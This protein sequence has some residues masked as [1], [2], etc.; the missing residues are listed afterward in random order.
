MK[1]SPVKEPTS[2]TI[3]VQI[4]AH[5]W[6]DVA[7]FFPL[8]GHHKTKASNAECRRIVVLLIWSGLKDSNCCFSFSQR[9]MDCMSLVGSKKRKRVVEYFSQSQ[10]FEVAQNYS[11]GRNSIIWKLS[12]AKVTRVSGSQHSE[13]DVD[14][15]AYLR[16]RWQYAG[17]V[18]TTD[19]SLEW[20]QAYDKS[21]NR[22]CSLLWPEQ[23]RW[24][25]CIESS[26]TQLVIGSP[27]YEDC[28][29]AATHSRNL[30]GTSPEA[31]AAMYQ[32]SWGSFQ[33]RPLLYLIRK[34]G[35]VYHQ[36]TNQPKTLRRNNLQFQ[37]NGLIEK[38]AEVDMSS[39]YWVLL[40][41]ML[42]A[43]RCK[44]QL[45]QD[46]T[47]GC[48]YQKLNEA[49]GNRFTDTQELKAH[50]NKDC[51]FGKRDFGKTPLFVSMQKLFPD[52]ARLI[53]HR[54]IHHTV[55]WLSDCLTHAES[56]FF[57]DLLLPYIVNAG[58]PALTIHD[59]VIV[60]ASKASQVAGY[61]NQ[62]AEAHFGF[63]PRFKT[64]L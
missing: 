32:Q 1:D 29:D 8:E 45:I 52:L 19:L 26:I 64:Q 41:A 15:Y 36:L 5:V 18:V 34:S 31:K 51:L 14:D 9:V 42:D 30:K 39:T 2:Q 63:C 40:T 46:L 57:V 50:V 38:T 48:F 62:L 16:T 23:S 25:P 4:D 13:C 61:C 22:A 10:Y 6:C 35:R 43:S 56:A 12:K 24:V 47:E 55:S 11:A 59:A 49:S 44:D 17:A 7:Q 28:L 53:R 54:R 58:T 27:T 3:Q 21:F 33:E 60:P 20:L 37:H